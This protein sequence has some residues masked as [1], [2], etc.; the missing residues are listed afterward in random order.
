M[1]NEQKKLK[2]ELESVN[3]VQ[4]RKE[5]RKK[6]NNIMNKIKIKLG[7]IEEE[8]MEDD[9]MKIERKEGNQKAHEA[10]KTIKRLKPSKALK[11]FDKQE[12]I[13]SSEKRKVDLVTEHFKI[14]FEKQEQEPIKHYP[15]CTNNPPFDENEIEKATKKLKNGKSTGEDEISAELLKHAPKELRELIAQI[16]NQSVESDEYLETLKTG[17]LNPLQKPPKKGME[18]KINVRPIILLSVIRKVM[19]ICVIGRT[20][21]KL[22]AK[23]PLDQAAYQSGR[24][25][26]EQVFCLKTLAE[27]AIV[28]ENYEIVFLMI[29]MSQAFD[30]VNRSE[31]MRQL[32]VFLEPNEMRMMY[33]LVK[34]V[35]LKVRIGKLTGDRISTTIGVCQGD[36]LSALLF[37]FYLAHIIK[38]FPEHTSREDHYKD[39]NFWSDLDW[40]VEKDRHKIQIDPKYADDVTFIRSHI[41]KINMVKRTIPDMLKEGNLIENQSKR[42]QYKIPDEDEKW[43]KCKCLGT[44]IDTEEDLKRRKGL[45]MDAMKTF[46]KIFTSN[47]LSIKTKIRTFN[48]YVSSVYLYN[49]ELWTLNKSLDEKID[50]FHRRLLRKVLN[51]KWPRIIR[52]NVLYEV[53]KVE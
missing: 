53:T 27:K 9:L 8:K 20:W 40:L 39:L 43:K 15:P 52:N 5:I 32:E 46:S 21:K 49:S 10:V 1:S 50:S 35:K 3:N 7:S 11:I 23:I 30:T 44:L 26:T 37:I 6:R 18:K 45:T 48:A 38:P 22:K 34:D 36:C 31:L 17:I 2:L 33:L 24:S 51:V 16:L 47:R 13:V 42:E 28:T 19:A 12:R 41:S 29:D 25:T 4:A 14:I